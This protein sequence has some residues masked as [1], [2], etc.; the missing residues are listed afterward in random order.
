LPEVLVEPYARLRNDMARRDRK[1]AGKV[2]SLEEAAR[3]VRGGMK[4]GVGGSTMS[5]TPM[6]LIWELIRQHRK[7][8]EIS[9]CLSTDG[10]LVIGS[11]IADT[12]VTSWFAQGILW[13]L[14]KVMR[15]HVESGGKRF[16]EWSHLAMGM[17]FRAGGMGKLFRATDGACPCGIVSSGQGWLLP[18]GRGM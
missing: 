11:D 15:H 1:P 8:L 3:V 7:H 16:E 5:R 17:R 9:R 2:V 6:A 13:R 10:D 12:V 18:N 14:S 4:V